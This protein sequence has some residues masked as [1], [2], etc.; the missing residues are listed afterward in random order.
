MVRVKI[1]G[2][3]NWNDA[4]M[5]I[6]EGADALG[7]NFFPPSPRSLT[8]AA[9][10]QI[11]RKMP[12]LVE[13]VGVFV[14]WTANAVGAL[15]GALR[16]GAVQ[17]H[18]DESPSVAGECASHHR[19]I[20]AFRVRSDFNLRRLAQYRA[21]SAF[22]LDG[23][24]P[25]LYGGTGKRVDLRIAQRAKK[26]GPIILAGGLTAENVGE[27]IREMRPYGVDVCGGVESKPGQKDPARLRMF[28]RAVERANCAIENAASEKKAVRGRES[29]C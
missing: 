1:C 20:K 12:P 10:W 25:K 16:L 2:I 27:D 3:T 9:A 26:F 18:G 22:L 29:H 21:A 11:I 28:M 8:P 15:A 6:D 5:A 23:F 13:A 14:N 7:F 24:D 19:V 4:K 17:L